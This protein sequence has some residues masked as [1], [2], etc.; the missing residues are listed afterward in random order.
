MGRT[1]EAERKLENVLKEFRENR[2]PASM[3]QTI[4]VERNERAAYDHEQAK[5]DPSCDQRGDARPRKQRFVSLSVRKRVDDAPEQ[6][7]LGELRPCE[8]DIGKGENPPQPN[9]RTK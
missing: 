6:N 1:V 9:L 8:Q 7:G 5:A 2:L 3:R 4:G